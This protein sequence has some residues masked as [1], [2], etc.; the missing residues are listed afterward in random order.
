MTA[1]GK[2]EAGG[3]AGSM[4]A[5]LR[6]IR[7]C[8]GTLFGVFPHERCV[9]PVGALPWSPAQG[10][11]MPERTRSRGELLMDEVAKSPREIPRSPR[12]AAGKSPR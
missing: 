12:D 3:S 11:K 5:S 2:P 6:L 7:P 8:G 4:R 1:T 10:A 9:S